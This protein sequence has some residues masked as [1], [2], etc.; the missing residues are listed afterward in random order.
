MDLR[1]NGTATKDMF[2]YGFQGGL[3]FNVVNIFK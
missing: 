1:D 2:V 3:K